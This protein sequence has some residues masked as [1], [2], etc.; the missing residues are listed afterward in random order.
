LSPTKFPLKGHFL[1]KPRQ[2]RRRR[3]T[4]AKGPVMK[5]SWEKTPPTKLCPTLNQERKPEVC[6]LENCRGE[7]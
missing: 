6:D 4:P 7:K 5:M 1:A 2:K 3:L